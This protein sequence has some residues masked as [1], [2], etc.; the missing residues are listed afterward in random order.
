MNKILKSFFVGILLISTRLYSQEFYGNAININLAIPPSNSVFKFDVSTPAE[1]PEAF[2]LP[3]VDPTEGYTDMALDKFGEFYYVTSS[4]LL[5][6]KSKTE[7]GCEFLGDFSDGPINSLTADSENYLYAIGAFNKLYRY[8]TSSG[9]FSEI[10]E[11]PADIIPGGDLFFYENRLFLTTSGGIIE[12]NMV[13]PLQSCPFISL[14]IQYPNLYAGFSVNYGTYSKAYVISNI[15]QNS[16][17]YEVDMVNKQ[18]GPPIR[19]YNHRIYGAATAYNLTSNNS[20]CSQTPLSTHENN[21]NN[22]YFNVI[23][24]TKNNIVCKTNI[25]RKQITQIR[26]FDNT[27]RLVKDFSNQNSL[28]NLD[29]SG[30]TPGN[31]LLTV[32]TKK[33]ETYTKKIISKG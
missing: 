25:D 15:S 2:C 20:T 24:P 12:I 23:N 16:I 29:I 14:D 17:L 31:Y 13:N 28:E 18:I 10:G 21:V 7:S 33:G 27:G 19:T 8:D 11:I 22:L 4:G 30:I 3:T 5:Y 1:I 26:L 6:R 32:A 9:V